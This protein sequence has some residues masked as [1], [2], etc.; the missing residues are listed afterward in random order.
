[1]LFHRKCQFFPLC[2]D[3]CSHDVFACNFFRCTAASINKNLLLQHFSIYAL[4]Q[5][6]LHLENSS[7]NDVD[8]CKLLW[9]TLPLN[10][11]RSSEMWQKHEKLVIKPIIDSNLLHYFRNVSKTRKGDKLS[12]NDFLHCLCIAIDICSFEVASK[13]RAAPLKSMYRTAATL[14]HHCVPNTAIAIDNDYKLKMYATVLIKAGDILYNSYTD[15]LMV[16]IAFNCIVY[17]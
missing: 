12:D 9:D 11:Y 17:E 7:I 10:E 1:M 3:C 2:I 6:L 14:P 8:A 15:P 4:L 5:L 13:V 16:I